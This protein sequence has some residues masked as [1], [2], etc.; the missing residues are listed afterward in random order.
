MGV[1]PLA[2]VVLVEL[3]DEGLATI[4]RALET[5]VASET[6]LVSALDKEE[7]EQLSALL[8]KL[9]GSLEDERGQRHARAA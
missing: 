2:A 7:R 6:R 5:Q 4:D 1:D 9:L 3:T 8:H